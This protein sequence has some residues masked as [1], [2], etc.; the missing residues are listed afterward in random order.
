[1]VCLFEGGHQPK[2]A[3]TAKKRHNPDKKSCFSLSSFLLSLSPK[4]WTFQKKLQDKLFEVVKHSLG[5][6][7]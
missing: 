5:G 7:P 4:K 6:P 3:V 2:K 1:M